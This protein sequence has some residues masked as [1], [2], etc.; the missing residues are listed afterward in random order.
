MIDVFI[1]RTLLESTIHIVILP[2]SMKLEGWA[3]HPFWYRRPSENVNSRDARG[4]DG[5]KTSAGARPGE[6]LKFLALEKGPRLQQRPHNS[7]TTTSPT[8][9]RRLL[10]HGY[11]RQLPGEVA[12]AEDAELHELL[13]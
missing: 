9:N 7:H 12:A 13:R 1:S 5:L 2:S 8:G 4:V 11:G 3:V 6:I 10:R